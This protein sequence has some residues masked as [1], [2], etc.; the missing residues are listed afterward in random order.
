MPIPTPSGP[1][2]VGTTIHEFIDASRPA[3]LMSQQSG[4]ILLAKTWYP[5]EIADTLEPE[6]LWETLRNDEHT[7]AALRAML[8]CM[9]ARASS[10]YAAPFDSNVEEPSLVIYNHG[11]ISFSSENTSLMEDLASHGC[12]VIS[13]QHA[14]QLAEMKALSQAQS[15]TK[16]KA[17]RALELQLKNAPNAKR[18]DL[19]VGYYRASTNTNRVVIERSLDTSFALDQIEYALSQIPELTTDTVDVSAAHLIGFSIGGAVA[20]ECAKRETRVRSVINLD[21]GMQGS[22]TTAALRPPYLMMYSSANDAINDRLLPACAT[23]ITSA[24]TRHLNFHDVAAIVPGLRFL[25]ATGKVNPS[26]FLRERNANA[27]KFIADA[28]QVK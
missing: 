20:T 23:T 14:E 19:A 2:R 24:D 10:C 9:R 26:A 1:Y 8:A 5:A 22:S 28:R 12:I 4:R 3:H 17:D 6:M 13:I 27:R 18:A 16:K 11:F 15:T 7:P 21:G 25:R